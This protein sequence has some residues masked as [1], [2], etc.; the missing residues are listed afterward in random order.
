LPG[1]LD[2]N[3]LDTFKIDAPPPKPAA[4]PK[5]VMP[6]PGAPPAGKPIVKDLEKDS[7]AEGELID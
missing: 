4:S 6:P 1:F 5:P 3:S 2:A 7:G